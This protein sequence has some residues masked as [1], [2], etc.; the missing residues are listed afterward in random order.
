M[1]ATPAH[2]RQ[3]KWN[4]PNGFRDGVPTCRE[5]DV[6]CV[7]GS[8]A[9]LVV[10]YAV[11]TPDGLAEHKAVGGDEDVAAHRRIGGNIGHEVALDALVECQRSLER[12]HVDIV[13]PRATTFQ[14]LPSE[15]ATVAAPLLPSV[16]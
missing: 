1:G 11:V 12:F 8:D 2:P 15:Q 14:L 6:P 13:A 4:T 10:G 5:P 16:T 3:P 9:P 7:G